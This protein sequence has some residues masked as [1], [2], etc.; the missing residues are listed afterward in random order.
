MKKISRERFEWLKQKHYELWDWL[1]KNPDKRSD[2]WFKLDENKGLKI[3][4]NCFACQFHEEVVAGGIRRRP[5]EY[6]P[7]CHRSWS[8][9]CLNG[10]CK[11]YYMAWLGYMRE[12]TR[13]HYDRAVEFAQEIR[14]ISWSEEFVEDEEN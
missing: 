2:D 7:I 9:E 6:C 8:E 12:K 10:L 5:C 14:D 4:E 1:S 13:Y 11:K 3:R